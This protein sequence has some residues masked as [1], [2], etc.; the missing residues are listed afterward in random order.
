MPAGNST[1]L[2]ILKGG[3]VVSVVGV[4]QSKFWVLVK[5]NAGV[6]GWASSVYVQIDKKKF[7]ALPVVDANAVGSSAPAATEAPTE[8]ATAEGTEEAA[9]CPGVQGVVVADSFSIKVAPNGQSKAAACL[10]LS[11][12]EIGL[13]KAVEDVLAHIFGHTD[14]GVADGDKSFFRSK[15]N[16]GADLAVLGGVANGII[17]KNA[18]QPL[19][20]KLVAFDVNWVFG[21]IPVQQDA[22]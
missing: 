21:E 1:P 9:S 3:D 18:E 16:F 14:A 10:R 19:Q 11:F 8:A 13:V 17:K 4:N 6:E 12:A 7:A 22:G 20:E 2:I 15:G 5:S